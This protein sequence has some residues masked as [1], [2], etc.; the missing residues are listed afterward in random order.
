MMGICEALEEEQPLER[1][2]NGKEP[3]SLPNSPKVTIFN[4]SDGPKRLRTRSSLL[5][6]PTHLTHHPTPKRRR[7]PKKKD[8]FYCLPSIQLASK[9]NRDES[10]LLDLTTDETTPDHSFEQTS[11]S[12]ESASTPQRTPSA[13]QRSDENLYDSVGSPALELERTMGEQPLLNFH[14]PSLE[15]NSSPIKNLALELTP[16]PKCASRAFLF[17][18]SPTKK[19]KSVAFSDNLASDIVEEVT[20]IAEQD[21]TTPRRSILKP[22]IVNGMSLPLDPNN[23]STWV[24]WPSLSSMNHCPN[25]PNFWQPGTIVQLE[26]KSNDLPQLVE[27][28][29]SV[30]AD[31][32]FDKKFEVYATLNLICKVNDSTT[33]KELLLDEKSAWIA[34]VKR[35]T[36]F[37]RTN[38]DQYMKAL[39][40]YAQR[41]IGILETN[42]FAQNETSH[43]E[44]TGNPFELRIL[45][46]VL[47]MLASLLAVPALNQAVS[48]DDMKSFYSHTCDVLIKP[49]IPK[50]LVAPYLN[51]IKDCGIS[52]KR[53]HFDFESSPNP[54][55][56]KLLFS[57]L[58]MKNFMS[59]TL[60]NE[61]FVA[62]RSLIQSFPVV[63]AKNFHL[64]FPGFLLDLCDTSFVLYGKVIGA[65]V[66]TLLE[67]A[68]SFLNSPDV[69][70]YA[71]RIL[72]SPLP[73][74]PKSWISESPPAQYYLDSTT[75]DHVVN[76]L[77]KLIKQGQYKNA[78]DIW[79]ALT[80]LLESV[81]HGLENWE[82]LGAWLL[83]HKTCFNAN[84]I[85]AKETA[86]SAW[87]VIAYK[88]CFHD[89]RDVKA[90]IPLS[91]NSLSKSGAGKEFSWWVMALRPKIKL[92]L[93]PFFCVLN[94]EMCDEIVNALH[95][96]FLAIVFNLFN[97]HQKSG[98]KFFQVCWERIVL[99]VMVNLYFR[100]NSSNEHMHKLGY[101][102]MMALFKPPSPSDKKPSNTRCLSIE[103][104]AYA[105]IY[106]FNA[107]WLHLRFEKVYP[108]LALALQLSYLTLETKLAVFG[109]FLN[110]LKPFFQKE[111]Q[112]SD[113]TF[114][115][116]DILPLAVETMF[117][118]AAISYEI[119][120]KV[121]VTLIDAFG[122][123]NLVSAS[124]SENVFGIVLKHSSQQCSTHQLKTILTM[125]YG[126]V[127]E[128]KSLLFLLILSDLY[129]DT[130]R[131]DLADFVGDCLNN[132]K[133]TKLLVSEML[134]CSKIFRTLDKNFAGMAKRLIQQIVLMKPED[135][136]NL[137]VQLQIE[138]W[139]APIF[140][141]FLTL[142]YDAP[143]DHLKK[144][145][146]TLI[147]LKLNEPPLAEL[148]LTHLLESRATNE[149]F[150]I[151]DQ[152]MVQLKPLLDSK[153]NL[154]QL[155]VTFVREFSGNCS[156]L[157]E[158]LAKAF[159]YGIPVEELANSR[160]N[161]LP[162]LK[163]AWVNRY[164]LDYLASSKS[165]RAIPAA[166]KLDDMLESESRTALPVEHNNSSD[167]A[168]A[169]DT[170]GVRE[171]DFNEQMRESNEEVS[172]ASDAGVIN[173]AT[174]ITHRNGLVESNHDQNQDDWAESV[175]QDLKRD[176]DSKTNNEIEIASDPIKNESI[177]IP[178]YL[179]SRSQEKMTG[180]TETR[181]CSLE[182]I[183]S[184]KPAPSG[185]HQ[186]L[187][188]P[189]EVQELPTV[190]INE[191]GSNEMSL[192]LVRN[193]L[194]SGKEKESTLLQKLSALLK[195][196]NASE[197]EQVSSVNQLVL[198]TQMMELIL[199]MRK[200]L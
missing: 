101:E 33:L 16:R 199:R 43:E 84:T 92:L 50:S 144:A 150:G 77:N 182:I 44:T 87:R 42:L 132:R 138:Q 7:K 159:K 135:F 27:G 82:H 60:I 172:Q 155:W 47:K 105:E 1:D 17:L 70:A 158:I 188:L 161:D 187:I 148:V 189:T 12:G 115:L 59:T 142:M 169:S 175:S 133:T 9:I 62:L 46:Q 61:K 163:S 185:D 54:L 49:R 165:F 28:C 88:I 86:L 171:K 45:N 183:N 166:A 74:D 64:W 56:E 197:L 113:A 103:P 34:D 80:L 98:S 36:G 129:G 32:H 97:F 85:P 186:L 170:E 130:R 71:R 67:A 137:F 31:A 122:A 15:L 154:R 191:R 174:I 93:Y 176:D 124:G 125:I 153:E 190:N 11:K 131:E 57:L 109:A 14:Q 152:V 119:A 112:P 66:T 52:A 102:I 173:I 78:M 118:N 160:W 168:A 127:S 19:R 8:A 184:L 111:V 20:P 41:D 40:S 63:L 120:I 194:E 143:Y 164:G 178:I 26:A 157:D 100:K 117:S 180:R 196:I 48:I 106:P 108:V 58:N 69:C 147:A 139:A 29:I 126:A 22:I 38:P 30:L 123:P 140:L 53:R 128:K 5:R 76:S 39:C 79:V 107:R 91:V 73:Q 146:L 89:L 156:I 162:L 151:A 114:D 198:E 177:V 4:E 181:L 13:A 110:A 195:E 121:L 51:I 37:N 96:S 95:K 2:P 75:I 193:G 81:P 179:D 192:V 104:I 72:S 21:M 35:C 6:S 68:R 99:P 25:S 23:S 3:R 18:S 10:P 83:V 24:K 136:G 134:L 55:L 149:I 116:I 200:R 167:E 141:F 90:L 65:G 145:T 94:C